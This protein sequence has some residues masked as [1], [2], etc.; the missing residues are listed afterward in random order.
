M[1]KVSETAP[2]QKKR[3]RRSKKAGTNCNLDR[4]TK[5]VSENGATPTNETQLIEQP[6][7]P[8]INQHSQN[9]IS[10][11]DG[12]IVKKSDVGNKIQKVAVQ[13]RYVNKFRR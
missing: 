4:N 13:K 7:S 8:T 1:G 3:K 5:P 12:H 11:E 10:K 6:E 2:Q 9:P